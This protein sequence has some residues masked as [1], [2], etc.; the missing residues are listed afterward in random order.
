MIKTPFNDV[1]LACSAPPLD[2]INYPTYA[3][4]K[5]DGFRCLTQDPIEPSKTCTAI[6][7]AFKPIRNVAT[8]NWIEANLPPGLDGELL[9][10]D[11]DGKILEYN[12]CQSLLT[13]F[14]GE[15]NFLYLVFD[16]LPNGQIERPYI[17]RMM[18]LDAWYSTL[19][20]DEVLK[21][22][23]V[24]LPTKIDSEEELLK[25]EEKWLAEGHEGVMLRSPSG[26]YKYGRAT[27][28]L[29][30]RKP[31]K[32]QWLMK[33]KRFMDSEAEIVS[34]GEET[35]I[36]GKPKGI[37]GTL[38]CRDF[39]SGIEFNIK[40]NSKKLGPAPYIKDG[41]DLIG[42]LV[43]YSYQAVGTLNAPRFP[44]VLGWRDLDDL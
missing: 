7:R 4:P 6:T 26:G 9:I 27:A 2:R 31:E 36:H 29:S 33:L 34:F 23:Q 5:L 14:E 19:A 20:S 40:Y 15:P 37:V 12:F 8:R 28:S 10:Q 42:K 16:I 39:K 38:H 22:V 17:E 30:G 11:D 32:Q 44:Q 35:S 18:N 3:T 1:M 13:R 24:V 25:I 41:A 43:K 21:H